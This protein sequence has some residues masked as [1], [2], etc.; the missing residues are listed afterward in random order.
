M[1]QTIRSV[2]LVAGKRYLVETTYVPVWNGTEACGGRTL[3]A[4]EPPAPVRNAP[5]LILPPDVDGPVESPRVAA[6]RRRADQHARMTKAWS[7]LATPCTTAAVA[8][9]QGISKDAAH[10]MIWSLINRGFVVR[11]GAIEI[12]TSR[13]HVKRTAVLYQRAPAYQDAP[14]WPVLPRGRA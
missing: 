12:P 6:R 10:R 5:R 4:Y 11:A 1:T 7:V 13:Q 2:E 9:A 3:G 8:T 14:S